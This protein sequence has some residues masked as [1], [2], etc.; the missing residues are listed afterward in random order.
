MKENKTNTLILS[1]IILAII[2]PLAFIGGI[3]FGDSLQPD[4]RLT[5]D[6]LSSWVASIATVSIAILT[7]FLAKETWYLRAAQ[8]EQLDQLRLDA[9]R[10]S[11]DFYFVTSKLSMQFIEL[12][13]KNNGKGIAQNINFR[14]LDPKTREIVKE[15]EIIRKIKN[16]GAI[17][18]GIASLGVEQI[19]NSFLFSFPDMIVKM[20]ERETFS[21]KFI[22]QILF[23]DVNGHNYK[24]EVTIDTSEYEGV[25]EI[26]N[27]DPM[28]RISKDIEKIADWAE[29]LTRNS[30]NRISVD[31][32]NSEEREKERQKWESI[33][34]K[35][36]K[37]REQQNQNV[38]SDT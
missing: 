4:F 21:T 16:L 25:V 19:Y 32:Y 33:R 15:N 1:V 23:T 37:Q 38:T 13:I 17:K 27:G 26:G 9:I 20:G 31:T 2:T 3:I 7:F 5:A 11:V 34:E 22:V 30:G 8:N 10:P 14:F 36:K 28:H 29:S 18:T 35:R 24:N 12:E 6:S